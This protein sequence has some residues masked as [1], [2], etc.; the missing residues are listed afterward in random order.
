MPATDA[1]ATAYDAAL[2]VL[3]EMAEDEQERYRVEWARQEFNAGLLPV[4]LSREQLAEYAGTYETRS[5]SVGDD[6][7]LHYQRDADSSFPLVPM[8]GGLFRFEGYDGARFQFA[9]DEAGHVD[10]VITLH[11]DGTDHVRRRSE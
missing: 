8:G 2:D 1:L 5:F 7:A 11:P 4:G 10:R 3:S 6:G 9:R